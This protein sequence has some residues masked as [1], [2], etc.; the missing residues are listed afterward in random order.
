MWLIEDTDTTRELK[1]GVDVLQASVAETRGSVQDGWCQ[2]GS[3]RHLLFAPLDR[4]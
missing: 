2:N 3:Q 1:S 4:P